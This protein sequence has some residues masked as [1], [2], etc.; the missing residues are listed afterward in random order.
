M[1]GLTRTQLQFLQMMKTGRV[2]V[3][4][5]GKNGAANHRHFETDRG[6]PINQRTVPSLLKRGMLKVVHVDG[7]RTLYVITELGRQM[8]ERGQV[9]VER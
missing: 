5:L 8:A 7:S 1:V 4:I 6:E 3:G 2:A 9:R